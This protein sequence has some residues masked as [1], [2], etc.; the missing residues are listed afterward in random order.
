MSEFSNR[1]G[2]SNVTSTHSLSL[3]ATSA[4]GKIWDRHKAHS[5]QVAAYYAS[6]EFYAYSQRISFCSNLLE[7]RLAPED[8]GSYRLNLLSARFCRVRHCPVCQ[9]RRSLAWKARAYKAIPQVVTNFPKYRWLFLTL[10]VKNCS[11]ENLRE[12]LDW[13]NKSFARFT[14]LKT[15]PA[16]GWIKSVEVTRGKD[17]SAHPHFHCLLLVKPSYF[18]GQV[19]LSQ[20]RW[21]DL[22]QQCLRIDYNPVINIQAIKKTLAPTCIIPEILKYQVKESDLVNDREW[23]L[24]LTRQLHGTRAIAIGGMLRDYMRDQV[25]E[26]E[27]LESEALIDESSNINDVDGSGLYFEW[28]H[29][30]KKYLV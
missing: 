7:F 6:S 24:E 1:D 11:V 9:W 27:A 15:W 30:Q 23:F 26:S 8:T 29:R 5:D 2:I 16:K 14:K 17:R 21:V 22:W 3:A 20:A 4:H 25:E 18:S 10:T 28:Q 19:Y 13:V 12:T